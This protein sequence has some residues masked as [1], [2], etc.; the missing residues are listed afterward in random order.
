MCTVERGGTKWLSVNGAGARKNIIC[1][2][3]YY[4]QSG[5]RWRAASMPEKEGGF[6]IIWVS[7]NNMKRKGESASADYAT[8]TKYWEHFK[9]TIKE[10]YSEQHV[11]SLDETGLFWLSWHYTRRC[12]R[13]CRWRQSNQRL[14][15]SSVLP[16]T[17]CS[18]E[19][20][21]PCQCLA[22]NTIF[23]P[24]N[25]KANVFMFINHYIL[26]CFTCLW[27]PWSY[28]HTIL[29]PCISVLLFTG[30]FQEQNLKMGQVCCAFFI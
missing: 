24:I 13:A 20:S 27:F 2:Y 12:M 7:L 15:F 18:Q 1:L 11:F 9:K 5:M 21:K 3:N 10:D 16:P 30:H 4:T 22:R 17:P 23:I 28:F 29:I 19:H 6:K 8:S 14:P 25:A 26:S